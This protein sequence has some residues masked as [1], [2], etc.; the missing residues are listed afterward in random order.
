MNHDGTTLAPIDMALAI[1]R[2]S[3]DGDDLSPEDLRLTELAANSL[4]NEQGLAR[5]ADLHSRV[6]QKC[7]VRPWLHNIEHL[8]KDHQGYVYW[9][10]VHVEHYSFSN[11]QA[12]REA[13]LG[14]AQ[15]CKDLE[16]IGLTP[17]TR[18]ALL[19]DRLIAY[20]K[21]HPWLPIL[22]ESLYGCL[23]TAPDEHGLV[24]GCLVVHRRGARLDE[25]GL[26]AIHMRPGDAAPRVEPVDVEWYARGYRRGDH[27]APKPKADPQ[28]DLVDHPE[29]WLAWVDRFGFTPELVAA[30]I[31]A[32]ES[33]RAQ[34]DAPRPRA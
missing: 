32:D 15:R 8:H 17:N 6:T 24:S 25:M 10:G 27:A 12:E 30:T 33:S 34:V 21:G 7:Y 29:E 23:E 2:G 3:N 28:S 1:L 18:T 20:G 11:A 16:N 13:A 31:E 19:A 5:L 14:L 9:K 22:S 4:L 26:L